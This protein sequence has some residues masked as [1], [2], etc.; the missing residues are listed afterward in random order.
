MAFRDRLGGVLDEWLPFTSKDL[1]FYGGLQLLQGLKREFGGEYRLSGPRSPVIG[2][3]VVKLGGIHRTIDVL[4][5]VV[6]LNRKELSTEPM[7]LEFEVDGAWYPCRVLPLIVMFQAKVANLAQLDQANRNDGKHVAI[8]V[9][10]VRT[11]LQELLAAVQSRELEPRGAIVPLEQVLKVVTSR[12]AAVC[13]DKFRIDFSKV[14]PR[15]LLEDPPDEWV[16]NFVEYR[17]PRSP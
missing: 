16:K 2:Q 11:Y 9:L 3:L 7:E 8:L 10:V 1:D 13:A 4:R 6:G 5:D 14:W 17:L 12:D 15:E